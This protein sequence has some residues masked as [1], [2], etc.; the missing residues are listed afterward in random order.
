MRCC[1]T[2]EGSLAHCQRDATHFVFDPKDWRIVHQEDDSLVAF[3]DGCAD[4]NR[5]CAPD[6]IYARI[7][8]LT[9]DGMALLQT[10]HE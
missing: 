4:R 6:L 2:F 1:G 10:M 7:D 5:H 9:P 3:C 8:F